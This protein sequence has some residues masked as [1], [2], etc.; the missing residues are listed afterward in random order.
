MQLNMTDKRKS[1]KRKKRRKRKKKS[2]VKTKKSIQQNQSIIVQSEE[3]YSTTKESIQ[4]TTLSKLEPWIKR[5]EFD[6]K[7]LLANKHNC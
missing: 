1:K 5:N 6:V 2:K 7:N 4:L 3:K